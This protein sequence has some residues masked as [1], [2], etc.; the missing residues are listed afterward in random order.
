MQQRQH[1]KAAFYDV[2]GTL[3]RTNI[4]HAYAYYAMN[5]GSVLG[6]ARRVLNLAAK[7]PLFWGLDK[8]NRKRFNESFYKEYTG[9]TEDRLLLLAQDLFDDVLKDA[10][11]PGAYD[12]IEEA[13]ASG[14]R[15]V[16]VTG[17]LD[18]TMKPLAAH[19]KADDLIANRMQFVDNV[20]TGK[21]MPPLLEGAHKAKVI[22][23]YCVKHELALDKSHAY[24]DSMSDYPMLAIV[25]RPTAVNPDL[26]LRSTARS[27][28]W[29][30]LD[31]R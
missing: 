3:I 14:C 31:I 11:F 24:T 20:A 19:L 13:R 21:V 2:D 7:A 26:R 30:I 27:Y 28:Q 9:L 25:G 23:D 18:F 1:K 22:R 5:E 17:A 15:I 6:S 29:P 10:I 12:L 8:F 16:L 4:V